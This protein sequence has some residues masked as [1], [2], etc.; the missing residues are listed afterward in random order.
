MNKKKRIKEEKRLAKKL[1]LEEKRRIKEEKRL[2]KKI[3]SNNRKKEQKRS[4]N[5]EKK[6]VLSSSIGK[7]EVN[8]SKFN[9]LVDKIRKKNSLRPYPDI[10]DIPN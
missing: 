2:A 6:I 9:D 8:L 3:K 7:L 10:N 5:D 4:N 1:E